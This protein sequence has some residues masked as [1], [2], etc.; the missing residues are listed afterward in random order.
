[1]RRT[2]GY[3]DLL[4]ICAKHCSRVS[5]KRCPMAQSASKLRAKRYESKQC[6]ERRKTGEAAK[7]T[8]SGVHVCQTCQ[9]NIYNTESHRPPSTCEACA[10]RLERRRARMYAVKCKSGK[11][12]CGQDGYHP[13]AFDLGPPHPPPILCVQI[14][15]C[16][17]CTQR[18]GGGMWGA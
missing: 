7:K 6:R 14:F 3:Q 18:M 2:G 12:G 9:L 4:L 15:N 16:K 8:V 1:M 5:H 17:F 11:E 10:V 13:P